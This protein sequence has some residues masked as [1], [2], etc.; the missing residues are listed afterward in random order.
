MIETHR[1]P[2]IRV[3]AGF[4]GGR[5]SGCAVI[6]DGGL[7]VI[8]RV[9][10]IALNAEPD[11]LPHGR[12]GVARVARK[13]HVGTQQ[14]EAIPVVLDGAGIGSPSEHGVTSLTVGAELALVQIR[15]AVRA[16]LANLGKDFRYVARITSDVFM[17]A[18]ELEV[19]SGI[20]VKLGP[21]AKR[22][23]TRG[24]M[25]VLAWNSELAMR[26]CSV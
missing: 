4:A 10:A 8:A 17:H 22:R 24:G 19:R 2:A 7:L 6:D 1:R 18:P 25:A 26:A 21:R 12:A 3:V 5:E 16:T 13:R 20:V 15:M 14:R 11:V 9:A 23:P